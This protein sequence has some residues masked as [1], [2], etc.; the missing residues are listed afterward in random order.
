M[1]PFKS[2]F[3]IFIENI[4][5]SF[6]LFRCHQ[7]CLCEVFF[8]VSLLSCISA[9]FILLRTTYISVLPSLACTS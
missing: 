3:R 9:D 6:F 2:F 7:F 5:F 8:F 1:V 4:G